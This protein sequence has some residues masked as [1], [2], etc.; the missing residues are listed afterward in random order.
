MIAE[1]DCGAP[2]LPN[3]AW[4]ARCE[5]LDGDVLSTDGLIIGELAVAGTPL[6]ITELA[7]AC[8]IATRTVLRRIG[9]LKASGRVRVDEEDRYREVPAVGFARRRD[10]L[11]MGQ[12][13]V[14]HLYS[15]AAVPA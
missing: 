5:T 10:G 13:R 7:D 4:C 9:R 11:S 6:T 12:V 1:C 14:G 3:R 2:A 15:L 8:G